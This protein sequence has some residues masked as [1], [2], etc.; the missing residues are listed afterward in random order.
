MVAPATKG[1][2]AFPSPEGRLYGFIK[3]G[4]PNHLREPHHPPQ[5]DIYN[6]AAGATTTLRPQACQTSARRAVNPHARRACHSFFREW[7]PAHF[8]AADDVGVEVEDRL[9]CFFSCVD[10][11]A[12]AAFFE[13]CFQGDFLYH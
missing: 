6:C 5:G 12:E 2:S 3:R 1:G 13:A 9:S 10:D 8:L 7:G 4:L 11:Q